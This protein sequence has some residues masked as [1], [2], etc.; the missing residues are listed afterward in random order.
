MAE[1]P[2]SRFDSERIFDLT[3][4]HKGGGSS[5]DGGMEARVTALEKKFDKIDSK[6]DSIAND[7][8]YI[9]GKIEGLPSASAFGEL[10]GRV[11]SLPTLSKIA[12]L[13]G[14]AVAA[15]TILNN[16]SAIKAAALG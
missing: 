10:K 7:M 6:L 14:F 13:V 16:W 1:P 2:Y 11:D 4:N 8:A 9:K 3:P 5:G 12:T 15:I